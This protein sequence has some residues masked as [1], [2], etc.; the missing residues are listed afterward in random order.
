MIGFVL[1]CVLACVHVCARVCTCVIFQWLS[2]RKG[3]IL[4]YLHSMSGASGRRGG[5]W[6]LRAG[7]L[8]K[9]ISLPRFPPGSSTA[10]NWISWWNA[11]P[12]R[13]DLQ[14]MHL[15]HMHLVCILLT[16]CDQTHCFIVP[17][18]TVIMNQR[19]HPQTSPAVA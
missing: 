15:L 12:A 1:A 19:L 17:C 9:Y 16:E 2:G 4:F 7:V 8:L 14:D 3:T 6:S 11:F 5:G 10:F 18:V 13:T